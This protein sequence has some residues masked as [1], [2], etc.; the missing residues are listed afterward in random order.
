MTSLERLNKAKAKSLRALHPP[1]NWK[2]LRSSLVSNVAR[3]C[4]KPTTNTRGKNVHSS[5]ND[6]EHQH[7]LVRFM[8]G[9]ACTKR[10]EQRRPLR[11]SR[12]DEEWGRAQEALAERDDEW[13]RQMGVLLNIWPGRRHDRPSPT[14]H[15]R[16]CKNWTLPRERQAHFPLPGRQEVFPAEQL[17]RTSTNERS[18]PW[19]AITA[20]GHVP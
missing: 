5:N 3:Y 6:L 8:Y 14:L 19:R 16:D 10:T 13:K 20:V 1:A 7:V 11:C 18:M 15:K 2:W 17:H 4:D 12:Q 9:E